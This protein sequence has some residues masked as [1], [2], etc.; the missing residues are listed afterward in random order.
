MPE[1]EIKK[2]FYKIYL[3]G[4]YKTYI[5]D[6]VFD[7]I[8]KSGIFESILLINELEN[9]DQERKHRIL[10]LI[11]VQKQFYTKND[12]E[13]F[14]KIIFLVQKK[15]PINV[16]YIKKKRLLSEKEDSFWVCSCGNK[17]EINLKYCDFCFL[18]K[19]GF[20]KSSVG[21]AQ[22]IKYLEGCIEFMETLK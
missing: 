13:D 18:D 19:Y 14:K 3:E 16:E 6:L 12:L 20:K 22:A 5:N 8:Q 4:K 11:T 10:K 9:L 1:D 15:F 17:N 2:L 7:V 21:P